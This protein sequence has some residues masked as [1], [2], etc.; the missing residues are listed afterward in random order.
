MKVCPVCQMGNS[1]E[2][3]SCKECNAPL[4]AATVQDGDAIL[5]VESDG[6]ERSQRRFR[7]FKMAWFVLAVILQICF[8]V[9]SIIR[10]TFAFSVLILLFMPIGGYI[11][12]F[13][14]EAMF[15]RGIE[16]SLD[17]EVKG[18][19]SPTVWYLLKCFLGG[20]LILGLSN[21][22]MAMIAFH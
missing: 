1:D 11:M 17:L 19:V 18:E 12:L 6:Y 10:G 4:G 22:F 9:V 13:H 2:S 7:I 3:M 8:L 15:K 20:V 14:S 5:E 21:F 16:R